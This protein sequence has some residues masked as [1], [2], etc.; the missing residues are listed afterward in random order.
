MLRAI[1]ALLS[2]V[3]VAIL[4]SSSASSQE[5]DASHPPDYPGV[6]THIPGVFITPVPGAPFSGTVEILSKQLLPNGSI[7]T[8]RT[9]NH[10]ARNSLGVIH[11][12][13]RKL[14]PPEFHGE[15]PILS[16][17][18]H[19]PQTRLSTTLFPETH[20]AKQIVLSSKPVAPANS[21]PETLKRPADAQNLRTEDLGTHDYAGLLC[22]ALVNC[23]PF[24]L[25]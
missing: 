2:L 17:R 15:P 14:E 10:I 12:E 6:R 3:L 21:T 16:S 24:L 13:M 9:L 4:S 23:G 25:N 22:M 5:Q 20:I 18:I 8:R 1:T 7:Y 19:D 11:N